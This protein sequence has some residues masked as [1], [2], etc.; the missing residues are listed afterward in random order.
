MNKLVIN[1]S[2]YEPGRLPCAFCGNTEYYFA[3]TGELMWH[4]S[5]V[6]SPRALVSNHIQPNGSPLSSQWRSSFCRMKC[7]V[8]QWPAATSTCGWS[9]CRR[10]TIMPRH[11]NEKR[12]AALPPSFLSSFLDFNHIFCPEYIRLNCPLAQRCSHRHMKS[13][14]HVWRSMF[15]YHQSD[16]PVVD[17]TGISTIQA[18]QTRSLN[19]EVDV[20]QSTVLSFFATPNTSK[21]SSMGRGRFEKH[22]FSVIVNQS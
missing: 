21:S 18:F 14:A 1:R 11:K 3:F 2:V 13:L 10:P 16:E 4:F 5:L 9:F 15:P 6:I 20:L 17:R 7:R 8:D 12:S 22:L 19:A